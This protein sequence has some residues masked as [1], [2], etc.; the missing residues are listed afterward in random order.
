MHLHKEIQK[1]RRQKSSYKDLQIVYLSEGVSAISK[2]YAGGTAS[3]I[4]IKKALR[5]LA[6]N[7]Q[8][9]LDSFERWVVQNLPTH[10]GRATP[11]EGSRRIYRA[12][13]VHNSGPFLRLPLN[14]LKIEKGELISV[15]FEKNQIVVQKEQQ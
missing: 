10:R 1:S 7:K 14:S 9:N 4:A 11:K 6:V 15:K 2:L 3:S 12:Q 8:I 13:R 5:A